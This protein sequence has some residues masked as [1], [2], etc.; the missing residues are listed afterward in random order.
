MHLAYF[1]IPTRLYILQFFFN[2]LLFLSLFFFPC[3]TLLTFFTFLTSLLLIFLF[4]FI[5]IFS[6]SLSLPFSQPLETHGYWFTT[7]ICKITPSA[8]KLSR[9]CARSSFSVDMYT[10]ICTFIRYP[11]LP[12]PYTSV[13]STV[14]FTVRRRAPSHQHFQFYIYV[15]AISLFLGYGSRFTPHSAV[16][17]VLKVWLPDWKEQENRTRDSSRKRQDKTEKNSMRIR[18]CFFFLLRFKY[19]THMSIFGNFPLDVYPI[20]MKFDINFQIFPT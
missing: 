16:V 17:Y 7:T 19:V 18:F 20:F 11:P 8:L 4:F 3:T 9:N 15:S 6:F 14:T 13:S 10:Y 2:F 5:P 12:P 1:H